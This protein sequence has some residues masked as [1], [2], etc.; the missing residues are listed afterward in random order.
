MIK[1]LVLHGAQALDDDEGFGIDRSK[2]LNA[3]TA[4]SCIRKQWFERHLPPVEQ[5]WGFARRGKQGEL[6]LVDCLLAS[7]A[8]LAYC[9][10]DQD[11]LHVDRSRLDRHGVQDDRPPHQPQLSAAC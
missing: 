9:G 4:D 8:E 1:D 2:Y 7:G 5:D 6:Y 10:D 3:S 11:R